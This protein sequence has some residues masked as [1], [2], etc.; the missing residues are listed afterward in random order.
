MDPGKLERAIN[1]SLWS[2][3]YEQILQEPYNYLSSIPGKEIRSKLIE[4]FNV[5]LEVP[6]EALG[7]I[8]NVVRMLHTA[9]LL[10]DDVEDDSQLRRGIPVTHK[11]Y[12]VPQTINTANY[13]YFQAFQELFKF[14]NRNPASSAEGSQQE[15]SSKLP[16]PNEEYLDEVITE[17]LINLH[18]GQGL[19]LFWRDSLTC[20]TEEEYMQMVLGKTGGLFRIAVK[21]M[22]ARSA[23]N[24]DY[25]PLVNLISI[26]FQ[27]RDDYMNLEST[28]YGDNKGYCEDLTEGKFSFPVV[29]AVRA[30]EDDRQILNILQKRTQDNA[31]KAHAVR[32][33]RERT[34]SFRYTRRV[35]H[36]LQEQ[37]QTEI[38]MLGGNE[39]LVKIVK[40]LEVPLEEGDE[41]TS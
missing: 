32:I 33:M 7:I 12:G 35:L 26:L 38:S 24:I 4:A 23:S 39:L 19:D 3:K 21:L 1:S 25:V 27:I 22:M 20:P 8:K 28:E 6:E 13:V 5:W 36:Q 14:R 11:I 29:H 16:E 40:A 15:G 31:L 37:V 30:S 34:G 18:R 17:E 41:A 9:S 2:P 10:M